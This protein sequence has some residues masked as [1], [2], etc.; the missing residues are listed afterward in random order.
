ML[1]WG[2]FSDASVRTFRCCCRS[3]FFFFK[4]SFPCWRLWIGCNLSCEIKTLTGIKNLCPSRA[5][6]TESHPVFLSGVVRLFFFLC[7]DLTNIFFLPPFSLKD[8]HNDLGVCGCVSVFCYASAGLRRGSVWSFTSRHIVSAVGER[9][10]IYLKIWSVTLRLLL[11]GA[12][13]KSESHSLHICAPSVKSKATRYFGR[14]ALPLD[15]DAQVWTRQEEAPFF[16]VIARHHF[17]NNVRLF[18]S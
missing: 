9:C 10:W 8:G 17:V 15:E 5:T 1:S 13:E 6:A 11:C 3:T 7:S 2:G 14:L 16:S 18:I 4:W 12:S